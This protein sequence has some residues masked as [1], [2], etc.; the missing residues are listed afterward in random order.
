MI[1]NILR[2]PSPACR[3]W[4]VARKFSAVTFGWPML[5]GPGSDNREGF[6]A[7]VRRPILLKNSHF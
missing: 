3:R 5:V 1:A 4:T 2:A 7:P 6:T